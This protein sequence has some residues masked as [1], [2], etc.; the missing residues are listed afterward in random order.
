MR[1]TLSVVLALL[2]LVGIVIACAPAPT[3]VPPT[4]PPKATEAKPAPAPTQPPAA[5]APTT[6][7]A[8]AGVVNRAGTKLPAD[9]A[10]LDKQ[11]MRYAESEAKW[12]TWDASVYDENVNDIYTFADSCARPD[13]EYVPQ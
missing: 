8:P 5:P 12:L 9:A 2:A 3:A 13:R 10:P 11:V 1:S 4:A 6:A 7:P